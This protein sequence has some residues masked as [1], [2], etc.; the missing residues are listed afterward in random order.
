VVGEIESR[1]D[2]ITFFICDLCFGKYPE[3]IERRRK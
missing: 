2:E 1:G 3:K